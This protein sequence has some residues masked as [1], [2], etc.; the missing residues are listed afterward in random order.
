LMK[1]PPPFRYLVPML[2]FGMG[3]ITTWMD[4]ELDLA[5]D[6]ER[7]F[8]EVALQAEVTGARLAV[9]AQKH[10]DRDEVT[11]LRESLSAWRDEPA[12]RM[13]AVVSGEGKIVVATDEA[14]E[15]REAADSP[16]AAAWAKTRK[17]NDQTSQTAAVTDGDVMLNAAFL[18]QT[19][20]H[21]PHWIL[22]V[23]NRS[24]A[25]SQAHLDAHRQLIWSAAVIA[26]FCLCLWAVLHLGVAVRLARLA[27]NVR[28]FGRGE[29]PGIQVIP[30]GDEVNE[31]S[32][33]FAEMG[34]RLSER[35]RRHLEL[36][37]EVIDSA[38]NERRRIGHEL[39]DSIGQHL[40][41]VLMTANALHEAMA[42]Q[43]PELSGKT[44]ALTQ[45]LRDTLAEVRGLSH[46]LAPVPLWER[47]LEYALQALADSTSSHS[48]VRCVFECPVAAPDC[49]EAV[50]GN[51]YRIAQE[52]V[53]NALKHASPKEIRIGLERQADSLVLE[54]DDDGVG[55]PDTLP[56]GAGIGFRVMRHR[57]SVMA[58]RLEAGAHPAG[59]TR[60]AIYV[61]IQL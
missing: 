36:E 31:L 50:A 25:I 27:D 51:L 54:V 26:F 32:T 16:V 55:L 52:A 30:G 56:A 38:E 20:T 45:Q 13:F 1:F 34:Q 12:L 6:L 43:A 7:H 19:Q 42:D 39:H 23:Y 17:E 21:G 15:G 5:N 33:A 4:Y 61:P 24:D 49:S 41:A 48:Q 2:L 40:T 44:Q 60:I 9:M 18:V 59:G 14:W 10:L 22:L 37:R 11:L 53:S 3:L 57:A 8:N 58:G 35:E 46:G 29:K 28:D 47:G